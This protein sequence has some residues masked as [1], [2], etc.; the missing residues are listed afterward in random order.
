[1]INDDFQ[2][3]VPLDA[4]LIQEQMLLEYLSIAKDDIEV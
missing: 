2:Q 3:N 4:K 1:M